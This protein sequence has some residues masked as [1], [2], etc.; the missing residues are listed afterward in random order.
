MKER[1]EPFMSTLNKSVLV[2]HAEHVMGR[3]F[4]ISEPFAGGQN[5]ACFEL[6]AADGGVVIVR[7]RLSKHPDS[8]DAANEQSELYSIIYEVATDFSAREC[9]NCSLSMPVCLRWS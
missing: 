9:Q 5:W 8:A 2:Q 7:V 6:N 3:N 4:S 1:L